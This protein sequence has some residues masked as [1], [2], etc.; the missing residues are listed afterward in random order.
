M[1][2]LLEIQFFSLEQM[3]LALVSLFAYL[4]PILIKFCIDMQAQR[5]LVQSVGVADLYHS[6]DARQCCEKTSKPVMPLLQPALAL[7]TRLAQ[8]CL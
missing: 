4:L 5:W 8:T 2:S 7:E 3:L 6:A 1:Q